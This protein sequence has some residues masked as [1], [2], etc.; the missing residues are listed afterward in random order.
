[1]ATGDSKAKITLTAEDKTRAAFASA[2]RG[3]GRL[4]SQA[5]DLVG[6][7]GGV[8]AALGA[9]LSA[10]QVANVLQV[11]DQLD[12]LSEKTGISVEQL[13]AL[14][15][16]GEA[17][18]TELT[19]LTTGVRELS[20]RM[21]DAAGG[22]KATSEAFR[23][24]G[25]EVKN[26]DGSLRSADEVLLDVA[27]RFA[28]YE[29]GAAKAAL[30]QELFGKS[31]ADMIPFLNQGKQGIEGLRRE[32]EQLGVIY[33]GDLAKASAEF[34]DNL[35]K[36]RAAAEGVAVQLGGPLIQE[37]TRTSEYFL[38]VAKDAGVLE[39]VFSTL[40]R[41]AKIRL[42]L[43]D[44]GQLESRARA[45]AA[46]IERVTNV[47]VGLQSTLQRDPGNERAQRRYN[48][49][50]ETLRRLQG[51]AQET[52]D[53]LK[54]VASEISGE[55]DSE[56]QRLLN[57]SNAA[58][59]GKKAAPVLKTTNNTP[60]ASRQSP[61]DYQAQLAQSVASAINDNAVTRA[62]RLADEMALL[63]KLFFDA[64][65]S[66]EV[67][68]AAMAKL[69]G[70]EQ[71]L[72]VETSD[73]L[74]EQQRLNELIEATPTTKLQELQNDMLLLAKAY[75]DGRFGAVGSAE[76]IERFNETAQTRLGTLPE[77]FKKQTDQMSEF[78]AE[79]ARNI[80]DSLGDSLYEAMNGNFESIGD[81]F[82]QMINR[83]VA[84]ALAAQLAQQLLGDFGKNGSTQLG[85]WAGQA[86]GWLGSLFGGGRAAGGTVDAGML[87]RVNENRTEFFRPN[88]G[89]EIIPLS[90]PDEEAAG[91]RSRNITINVQMPQNASRSTGTQFG[92]EIA[93]QLRTA[94]TRNG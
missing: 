42:G 33:S 29:D 28:Q 51:E 26:A 3:L 89:G 43:D 8:G 20:K 82:V 61:D 48:N 11:A 45:Q 69:T 37:L 7:L 49:L 9:G 24:I 60:K 68:D 57:R 15:F 65:L 92:A 32:A 21:A 27:D 25:V 79:A 36:L 44:V 53:A 23:A 83:M 64:G 4:G 81:G 12:D 17:V 73:F 84:E 19:S 67:Y 54:G 62:Q 76:A 58:Q 66:A 87:Y 74:R 38:R 50:R 30:A 52:T 78:A 34:N 72:K 63:D 2:S 10:L 75:E 31:G 41:G 91:T 77:D 16:A 40:A 14:R 6:K 86:V 94:E 5:G 22:G 88:V 35:V 47:L 55:Q 93:R 90:R 59:G 13:S 85:G 70:T 80:Q 56:V 1:M 18:G 39:A 71:K 46:E